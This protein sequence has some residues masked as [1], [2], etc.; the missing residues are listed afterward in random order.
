MTSHRAK[1]RLKIKM[2]L[3]ESRY[4][5]LIASYKKFFSVLKMIVKS[6]ERFDE[7]FKNDIF[8]NKKI[9]NIRLFE[10]VLKEVDY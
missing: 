5:K 8:V 6:N 10:D 7:I 2:I 3:I 1:K 9:H 4:P